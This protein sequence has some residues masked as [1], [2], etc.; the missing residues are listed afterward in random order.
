MR[1]K[2]NGIDS[3]MMIY[4]MR[5]CDFYTHFP[6]DLWLATGMLDF[7]ASQLKC[8]PYAVI[9]FCDSLHAYRKDW[10]KKRIF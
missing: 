3:M 8:Y 7:F 9:Y 2:I 1:R 6:I 5:S 10:D 4:T